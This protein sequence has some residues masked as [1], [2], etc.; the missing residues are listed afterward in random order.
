[1]VYVEIVGRVERRRKWSVEEKAA[2][3]AEIETEETP[4]GRQT[5][6][7]DDPRTPLGQVPSVKRREEV[8]GG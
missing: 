5:K 4:S 1:M 3:L 2:L 7:L 6:I 8:R